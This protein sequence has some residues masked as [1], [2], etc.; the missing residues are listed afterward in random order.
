MCRDRREI[1][2]P[3][4]GNAGVGVVSMRGAP[5][6]LPTFATAQFRRFLSLWSVCLVYGSSWFRSV[7]AFGCPVRF[8]GC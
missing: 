1:F 4:V 3:H 7:Y 6:A 2:L 8:P 5:L